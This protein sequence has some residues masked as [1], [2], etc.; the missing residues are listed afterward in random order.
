MYAIPDDLSIMLTTSQVKALSALSLQAA[1]PQCVSLPSSDGDD[2]EDGGSGAVIYAQLENSVE[3]LGSSSQMSSL[4]VY[5]KRLREEAD[6]DLHPMAQVKTEPSAFSHRL[7]LYKL[8]VEH[9]AACTVAIVFARP[10]AGRSFKIDFYAAFKA[11]DNAHL[12]YQYHSL[13]PTDQ[14]SKE[15]FIDLGDEHP[16][17]TL[18]EVGIYCRGIFEA[19]TPQKLLQ[20]TRLTI[21]PKLPLDRLNYDFRVENLKLIDRG[22]SPNVHRRLVWEWQGDLSTLPSTLPRSRMTGPFSHFN[23]S[24]GNTLLGVSH[25]LEFPISDE[26]IEITQQDPEDPPA[27]TVSGVCFGNLYLPRPA[28][29]TLSLREQPRT[30]TMMS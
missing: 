25:C 28:T 24:V 14:N 19:T 3:P 13:S 22:Q 4:V 18:V 8:A 9:N 21:M 17:A 1:L 29:A 26:D 23:I 2:A 27:F 15:L 12:Q 5:G 20:L 7:C 16:Q 10:R 6:R 11:I 30:D